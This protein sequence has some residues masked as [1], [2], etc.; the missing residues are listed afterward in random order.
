MVNVIL[1]NVAAR[2]AKGYQPAVEENEC[3]REGR[4]AEAPVDRKLGPSGR[5]D[6]H[7]V[8]E[9]HDGEDD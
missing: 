4:K 2:A 7:G 1:R 5:N 9:E 6:G 8:D 3:S